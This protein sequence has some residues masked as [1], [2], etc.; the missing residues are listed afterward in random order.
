MIVNDAQDTEGWT[1][2]GEPINPNSDEPGTEP[3]WGADEV[4]ADVAT[5]NNTVTVDR[6]F[7]QTV[8]AAFCGTL[9]GNKVWEGLPTLTWPGRQLGTLVALSASSDRVTVTDPMVCDV[10]DVSMLSMVDQAYGTDLFTNVQV[11]GIDLADYVVEY[12]V[13]PNS[14]QTQATPADVSS[15]QDAAQTDWA[16]RDGEWFTDPRD[17]GT[18]WQDHINMIRLRPVVWGHEETG[19][20]SMNLRTQLRTL[21]VYNGGPNAGEVVPDN[22]RITNV[23][24][25]A[26]RDPETEALQSVTRTVPFQGARIAVG[27]TVTPTQ[28]FPGDQVIWDLNMQVTQ[29][30]AGTELTDLRLVDTLPV[31]MSLDLACTMQ[32]LPDGVDVAFNVAARTATFIIGDVTTTASPHWVVHPTVAGAIRLQ[33]CARVGALAASGDTF[34]NRIQGFARETPDSAVAISTIQIIGPGQL[35]IEKGVDKP[36]VASGEPYTWTLDW[37]NTSTTTAFA[38]PDIIDVLPWNGDAEPG[39]GSQRSQFGS[40][41]T[42]TVDLTGP[43]AAP[44]YT[45][46]GTGVGND[47]PGTWYYTTAAPNTLSHDPRAAAN[48]NPAAP[49]GLWLIAAEVSDFAAVTGIRFVSSTAIAA[50]TRIRAEIPSVSA[51]SDLDVYY[52]NRGAIF[53]ATSPN[54][55]L[56]S[57]EPVVQI[58]GFSLGDL[59]WIE[60]DGDGRFTEGVDEPVTGVVVEVLDENDRVVGTVTTDANGRWQVTAL[61]AG[62]YRARIPASQFQPGG[63]LERFQVKTTG[64]SADQNENEGDSNSNTTTADPGTTGLVSSPVALAYTY[65]GEGEDRRLIGANG[66]TDDDVANLAPPRSRRSSRTSRW[67][68]SWRRLRVWTSRSIR[69]RSTPMSRLARTSRRGAR[70]SGR[71]SSPTPGRRSCSTST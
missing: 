18:D 68:C 44:T 50:N 25:W 3:G 10:W 57:N 5:G 66:P 49:G 33:L 27:K 7:N 38:S 15:L 52:V 28:Y 17:Y 60:R 64:S 65:E 56:L 11:T 69:I 31:G 2:D 14:T 12:A 59:V 61:P 48:A 34:T 37:G 47:V 62:T 54:A 45:R 4:D 22:V 58:P 19:P 16:D 55:L 29:A 13:G 6:P 40:D 51:S 32:R 24:S 70:W 20:F 53:T 71:T 41:F 63:P 21:G 26:D 43:L 36:Y 67:T 8:S 1:A 42:G 35:G 23:G 39:V 30:M 46:G 9:T